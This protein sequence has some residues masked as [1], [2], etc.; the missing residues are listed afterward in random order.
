MIVWNLFLKVHTLFVYVHVVCGVMQICGL[1]REEF[2]NYI[3]QE[4][5]IEMTI[6]QTPGS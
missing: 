5:I 2:M 6:E 4:S 1:K 3:L